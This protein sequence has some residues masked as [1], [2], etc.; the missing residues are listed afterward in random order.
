MLL[1]M[2]AVVGKTVDPVAPPSVLVRIERLDADLI[3]RGA[4]PSQD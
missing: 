1:K 4:E 2:G 3:P